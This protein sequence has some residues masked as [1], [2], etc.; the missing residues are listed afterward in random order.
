MWHIEVFL[1]LS[2]LS[3][4][5]GW[6]MVNGFWVTFFNGTP[7]AFS[8]FEIYFSPRRFQKEFFLRVI[9]GRYIA[10]FWFR[11]RRSNLRSVSVKFTPL[12]K[13]S[14][15]NSPMITYAGYRS[16]SVCIRVTSI[17][18]VAEVVGVKRLI[19]S[20]SVSISYNIK[21]IGR[22]NP[23]TQFGSSIIFRCFTFCIFM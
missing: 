12:S 4:R 15:P 2:I 11:V 14:P 21:P 7:I 19:F 22:F 13:L 5:E 1:C 8:R 10:S 18:S 6:E 9:F 16:V 23:P 17:I 3:D 20:T